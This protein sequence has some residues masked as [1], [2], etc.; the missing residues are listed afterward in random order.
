MK[1]IEQVIELVLDQVPEYQDRKEAVEKE[2]AVWKDHEKYEEKRE[3]IR[4]RE[5][6]RLF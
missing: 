4:L 5:V 6:A 2:I 3:K 1:P